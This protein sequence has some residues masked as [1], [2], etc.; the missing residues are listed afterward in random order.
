M[1]S[2]DLHHPASAAEAAS[3]GISV[4][5]TVRND[6]AGIVTLLDALAGQ[7]RLPDEIMILDGGSTDGTWEALVQEAA[8]RALPIRLLRQAGANIAAGR[9]AAIRHVRFSLIACTDAGCVPDPNWLEE[10]IAPFADERVEVV[11][12]AY[13][14]QPRSRL[15]RVAGLLTLPGQ[16]TPVNAVTF[17]PSARSLAFRKSAWQRAGEFPE[18]LYTAEDTLFA[19]KLRQIGAVFALAPQAVVRWRPRSSW[20]GLCRQF[21]LYA[22][23]EG[24][25]GRGAGASRFWLRRYGLAAAVLCAAIL[26][27]ALSGSP[28]AVAMGMAGIAALLAGPLHR[29][30]WRLARWTSAPLDYALALLVGHVVAIAGIVGGRRGRRDRQR[31]PG[32][33]VESLGQYWGSPQ[34]ADV[35]PWTMSTATAPRT[36]VVAWHYPPVSRACSAVLGALFA[37]ANPVEFSVLTRDLPG[38]GEPLPIPPL[39]TTRIA[40]PR[41]DDEDVGV[42]TWRAA[43]TT[44]LRMV[45]CGWRRQRSWPAERLLAVFPHRYGLLAGWLLSRVCGVPLVAYMHDLFAET[46]ITKSRLKRAFWRALDARVI[47]DAASLLVPTAE[48]AEHYRRRSA[49]RVFVLPHVCPQVEPPRPAG[50]GHPLKLL[51]AGSAYQ[52][53]LDALEAF[54]RAVAEMPNVEVTYLTRPNRVLGPQRVQWLPRTEASAAMRDADVLVV[55]LGKDTPWPEE[56]QGCFPSKIANYLALGRP[57]LA[58]VP[59]NSFV[60]RFIRETGCGISTTD[61]SAEAI[62]AAIESLRSPHARQTMAEAATRAARDLAPNRWMRALR[63]HLAG[64]NLLDEAQPGPAAARVAETAEPALSGT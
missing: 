46:L 62:R 10:I 5:V 3:L 26:A 14:V 20:R 54:D 55:L 56:V 24:R 8:A 43:V 51:Y 39:P 50:A 59:P 15:E 37:E 57:I 48:F 7:T 17:N 47:R 9:N 63:A 34:V 41:G 38:A 61:L 58:V 44:T 31:E 21:V 11:G 60:D 36:L 25:L 45:W 2:A 22:E 12:G 1:N 53:H 30:A 29:R 18:W 27:T 6:R 23:G 13:R 28:W 19:C 33:Y 16:L 49:R 64:G 35:P 32:R 40:W 4:I 52:A 42:P